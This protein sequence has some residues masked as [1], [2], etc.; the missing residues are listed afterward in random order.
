VHISTY[1][2]IYTH[3]YIHTYSQRSE[4]SDGS[5]HGYEMLAEEI[6]SAAATVSVY[7]HAHD[8][9]ACVYKSVRGYEMIDE[10]IRRAAATFSACMDVF[11][12]ICVHVYR[13]RV[14]AH[15]NIHTHK[16]A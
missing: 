5:D 9:C 11:A 1:T 10:E 13:S 7:V 8:V 12:C 15:A 3:T 16:H 6:G 4:K 14:T 2:H